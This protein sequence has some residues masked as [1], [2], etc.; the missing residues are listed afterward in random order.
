MGPQPGRWLGDAPD[1]AAGPCPL[2]PAALAQ[3]LITLAHSSPG[4]SGKMSRDPVP[5]T[6]AIKRLFWNFEGGGHRCLYGLGE[7]GNWIRWLRRVTAAGDQVLHYAVRTQEG[8]LA[9]TKTC[10]EPFSG[11]ARNASPCYW[12][13]FGN[14]VL[15]EEKLQVQYQ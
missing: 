7:A 14:N 15:C 10:R 8:A 4:L 13:S 1:L 11:E 3:P 12:F 6:R 2:Q 9:P 5:N